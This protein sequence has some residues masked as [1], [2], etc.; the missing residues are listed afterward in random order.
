[1]ETEVLLD[2]VEKS[3]I[4]KKHRQIDSKEGEGD[5]VMSGLQAWEASQQKG[6]IT[7]IGPHS[8]STGKEKLSRNLQSR[9]PDV[10]VVKYH[11]RLSHNLHS[12]E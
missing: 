9:N 2:E 11:G 5:P 8:I 4:A 3:A 6:G 12:W 10:S 1:M 7:N